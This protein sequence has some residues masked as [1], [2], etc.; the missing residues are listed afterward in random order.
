MN[1]KKNEFYLSKDVKLLLQA[2]QVKVSSKGDREEVVIHDPSH[3]ANLFARRFTDYIEV[4]IKH[5]PVFR[6]I[7]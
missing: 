5:F 7:K 1:D 2:R 6:R 3:P 4:V